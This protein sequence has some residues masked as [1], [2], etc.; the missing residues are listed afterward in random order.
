MTQERHFDLIVG[1]ATVIDG[2]AAPRY[3]ADIGV[4]DGRI[5]EI[6]RLDRASAA[7][8]IDASGQTLELELR[9]RL[10]AANEPVT[11]PAPSG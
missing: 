1:N 9:Y 6:G 7:V 5:T 2:T 10:T 8:E 11:I 4:R 3:R